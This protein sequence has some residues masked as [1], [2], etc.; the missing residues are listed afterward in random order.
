MSILAAPG[1]RAQEGLSPIAEQLFLEGKAFMQQKDYEHACEKLKASYDLDHTATGTLLNLALCHELLGKPATAW[2]EFRQVAAESAARRPDRVALARE[3][4]TALFP[5]LSYVRIFV[6]PDARTAG[7]SIRLDQNLRIP[8]SSWGTA[9]PVDPGKHAIEATAPGKLARVA[10][11]VIG[12]KADR[13]SVAVE[14]LEAAP[15]DPA[16]ARAAAERERLATLRTRRVIG[17]TVGGAG[18]VAAG[19]GVVFGAVA[20]SKNK[21]LATTCP[22]DQC[23]S[24][25]AKDQANE[26][27]S[28]AKTFATLSNI[29]VG[30]ASILVATGVVLVLTARPGKSAPSSTSGALRMVPGPIAYGAGLLLS[31]DL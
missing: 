2:V 10:E 31:G 25:S 19:V 12:A 29:T 22:N 8:E 13:Q 20:S 4:E 17:F 11:F 14:P 9:L 26:S 27:L 23:P 3:H 1:A 28:S 18:L 5:L 30:A 6:P 21:Q 15:V 24:Q 7:L 16:E